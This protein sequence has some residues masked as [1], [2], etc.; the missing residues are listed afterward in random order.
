MDPKRLH[1][2]VLAD[3]TCPW[4]FIGKRKLDQALALPRNFE[5]SLIWRPYQLDPNA[6]A[7]GVAHKTYMREKFGTDAGR[8]IAEKINHAAE[9][10]GLNFDFS[11]IE[12]MPNT[13]LAHRLMLFA[14]QRGHQH[15]LSEALFSAYF[16]QGI[17]IGSGPRLL[18]IAVEN[19]LPRDE[20][21]MALSSQAADPHIQTS[22]AQAREAG[23]SGVPAFILGGRHTL[24]GA[25]DPDYLH[26]IFVK[27]HEKLPQPEAQI[28]HPQTAP[29]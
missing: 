26:R 2:D 4:C 12:K 1:I 28:G 11:R 19:G 9:G 6:P 3:F 13:L 8:A 22:N 20:S 27:A 21:E 25:Q 18:D 10:T 16:E 23:I 14:G 7:E 15:R 24:M 29:A 5:I 17:D